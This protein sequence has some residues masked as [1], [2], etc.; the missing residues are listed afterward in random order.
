MSCLNSGK[1]SLIL[2]IGLFAFFIMLIALA[3]NSGYIKNQLST[4]AFNST[5]LL[6][7]NGTQALT[8]NWNQ[9]N[10]NFTNINSW[11]L[12]KTNATQIS[13]GIVGLTYIP[14][15]D[16]AH[17]PNV[18]TLSYG[19]TF[20][21]AQIPT[22]TLSSS[23]IT[24]WST[25][26]NQTLLTT[27]YP[28][29]PSITIDTFGLRFG[30]S[31]NKD[32]L[33]SSN[34]D[35]FLLYTYSN[36][37]NP[38]WLI[39]Y[40]N[41]LG[42]V[43]YSKEYI[44]S[45]A[46]T[47]SITHGNLAL[48]NG[49]I[50]GL[51]SSKIKFS[52]NQDWYIWF[53]A[54]INGMSIGFN[55]FLQLKYDDGYLN[56]YLK[57][58]L[59]IGVANDASKIIFSAAKDWYVWYDTSVNGMKLG[60]NGH[61]VQFLYDSGTF[62]TIFQ[63]SVTATKGIFNVASG[64]SPLTISSLTLVS[65]LNADLWDGY[66]FSNYL[67]QAVKTTSSPTLVNLNLVDTS[68]T[69]I[70]HLYLVGNKTNGSWGNIT[71]KDRFSANTWS[72]TIDDSTKDMLFFNNLNGYTI[73]SKFSPYASLYLYNDVIP[74]LDSSYQ[75]GTEG[76]RWGAV[77]THNVY[78][79]GSGTGNIGSGSDDYVG[80]IYYGT[81]HQESD[82]KLKTEISSVDLTKEIILPDP[83][84][85]KWKSSVMTKNIINDYGKL[86]GTRENVS[87]ESS[88]QYGFLSSDFKDYPLISLD[89]GTA[90]NPISLLALVVGKVNQQDLILGEHEKRISELEAMILLFEERI[91]VLEEAKK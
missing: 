49:G 75:F 3:L 5:G 4:S 14:T 16:D 80:T 10:Y 51:V 65:N 11:F 46:G 61:E 84:I 55:G 89:D 58:G 28:S 87:P 39:G 43:D 38:N 21:T 74:I 57:G 2:V 52:P 18:E 54:S 33:V 6:F 7:Q 34:S 23:N 32:Y 73:V 69:S 48:N 88:L 59:I 19:G 47:I 44:S 8:A 45:N 76:L 56:T 37:P 79:F 83:K 27:S 91:K 29:F 17:I 35:N 12:G 77:W 85:F 50:E 90:Y 13:T 25:Y 66:H 70:P 22:L 81:L 40:G 41:G 86:I 1:S 64:T 53:D 20:V 78:G 67:N 15:M 26:I 82:E 42:D 24:D 63:G 62:S 68:G 60:L 71:F 30:Y 72:V 31:I 9:G 36:V